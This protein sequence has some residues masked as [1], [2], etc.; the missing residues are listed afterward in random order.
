MTLPRANTSEAVAA[1]VLELLFAGELRSGQRLDLDE[2]ASR[3]G[4]SR[5]PVR[6]GLIQLERDGLVERA[7]YKRAFVAEFDDATVRE[8]FEL[9]GMLS[10]LTN[11]RVAAHRDPTV[12]S[13]LRKLDERLADCDDPGEFESLAREFRRVVNVAGARNHLRALLRTFSG[14]VPAAARFSIDDALPAERAALHAEYAAIRAGDP[15]AAG[16]AALAHLRLTADNAVAALRRRGVFPPS[17]LDDAEWTDAAA[18]L[19]GTTP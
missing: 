2:I 5:V 17:E 14:L 11:R 16:A 7:H 13:D 1:H 3:L 6:E 18:V 15:D 4:V 19:K 9:Y 10:A 12:L 8:A